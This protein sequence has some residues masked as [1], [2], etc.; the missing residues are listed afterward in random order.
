MQKRI[1]NFGPLKAFDYDINIY[2]SYDWFQIR[3]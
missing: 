2:A 3:S 1:N